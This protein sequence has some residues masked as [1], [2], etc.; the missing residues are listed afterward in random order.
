[1]IIQSTSKFSAK[2]TM[3]ALSKLTKSAQ[4]GI[5]SNRTAIH[6]SLETPEMNNGTIRVLSAIM[7]VL[8]FFPAARAQDSTIQQKIPVPAGYARIHYPAGSYSNWIQSLPLKRNKEIAVYN[9]DTIN[10]S[11]IGMNFSYNVFAVVRMP[12]LFKADLEQCADFSMRFWAEYHKASG[13]LDRLYLFN[14]S[15]KRQLFSA[16]GLSYTQFV[17]RA[18]ANTNSFSLKN[19]CAEVADAQLGPGD[20]FVQNRRGGIGH[21]SVVVDVCESKGSDRLYLIGYSFMP[22]QEFH[23]EKASDDYG[24]AGWFTLQGYKKY[25]SDHLD[26]GTPVLRRFKPL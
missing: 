20:M 1:M 7:P 21:V 12:L 13:K 17:K 10:T 14:Y 4:F 16:S 26:F 15:G 5:F 6:I 23:I 2:S 24:N 18:F 25:L 11:D 9:G 3:I 8:L 22:A 19:G